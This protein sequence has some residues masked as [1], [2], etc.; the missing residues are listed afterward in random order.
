[1]DNPQ[2][3]RKYTSPYS[4]DTQSELLTQGITHIDDLAAI[5]GLKMQQEEAF[6]ESERLFEEW[7]DAQ[8]FPP[9]SKR[10]E[11]EF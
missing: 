1:M 11:E 8:D 7:L 10:S 5:A 3:Q 9:P 4:F 6:E 2:P